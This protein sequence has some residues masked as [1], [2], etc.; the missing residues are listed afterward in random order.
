MALPN[1]HP[2]MQLFAAQT[3]VRQV[4]EEACRTWE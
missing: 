4:L 2:L 1:D 3:Q